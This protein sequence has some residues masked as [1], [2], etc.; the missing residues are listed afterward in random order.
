MVNLVLSPAA[1]MQASP[2]L[3]PEIVLEALTV[4]RDSL[5]VIQKAGNSVQNYA[6]GTPWV[7]SLQMTCVPY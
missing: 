4:L 5:V 6:E 7:Q 2:E 1:G 3:L